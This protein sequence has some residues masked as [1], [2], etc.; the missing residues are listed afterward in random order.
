L[1][2]KKYGTW[3]SGVFAGG[4]AILWCFNGGKSW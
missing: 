3:W 1:N 4:F 2:R